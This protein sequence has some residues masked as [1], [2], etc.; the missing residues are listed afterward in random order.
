MVEDVEGFYAEEDRFGFGE[1]ES[2]GYGHVVVL[3]AGAVEEAAFGGAGC[4]YFVFAEG[5]GAE[6]VVSVDAG[7][8]IEVE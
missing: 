8:V 5:A 3:R 2:F 1:G 6:V 4:A 7:V